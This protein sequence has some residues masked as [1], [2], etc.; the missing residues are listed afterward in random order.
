MVE[1]RQHILGKF[2]ET[3]MLVLV[4]NFKTALENT[5]GAASAPEIGRKVEIFTKHPYQAT[6]KL[7]TSS[8]PHLP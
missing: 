8:K 5:E 4:N 2:C 1:F 7:L 6:R 3:P